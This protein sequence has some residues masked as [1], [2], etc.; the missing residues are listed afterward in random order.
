LRQNTTLPR[1]QYGFGV[2]RTLIDGEDR[3]HWVTVGL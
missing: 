2:R 3:A 1:Q